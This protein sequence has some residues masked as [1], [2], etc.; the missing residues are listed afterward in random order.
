M[1]LRH[2]H[3]RYQCFGKLAPTRTA[4][5]VTVNQLQDSEAFLDPSAD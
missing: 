1:G 4:L 5:K 2:G 3:P